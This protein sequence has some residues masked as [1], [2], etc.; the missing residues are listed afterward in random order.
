MKEDRTADKKMIAG[1]FLVGIALFI[2]LSIFSRKHYLKTSEEHLDRFYTTNL[3]GEITYLSANGGKYYFNLNYSSNK[4]FIRPRTVRDN[5][6]SFY[7]VKVGDY[8]YKGAGSD[9]VLIVSQN[10][11]L[12]YTFSLVP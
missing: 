2:S 12:Y 7:F 1:L 9:T 6:K 10:D 4:Y 3:Q 11:S 5:Q 8:F